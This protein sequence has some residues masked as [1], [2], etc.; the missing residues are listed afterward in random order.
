MTCQASWRRGASLLAALAG[1]VAGSLGV[2]GLGFPSPAAAAPT[3]T[4]DALSPSGASVPAPR[5]GG[6]MA[7]DGATGQVVLFG[8]LSGNGILLNDTWLWNG[9]SWTRAQP[10][11]SPAPT[12]GAAMAYDDNLRELILFGGET[13]PSRSDAPAVVSNQTWAWNGQSWYLIAT[14]VAPPARMGA[15]MGT[16]DGGSGQF[17]L[18]GGTAIDTA[19]AGRL[20]DDTWTF[21]G[22]AWTLRGP[23]ST[24]PPRSAA[25]SS[26]D[27]EAG[28]LVLFGGA[29]SQGPSPGQP[30]GVTTWLADTWTWDGQTWAQVATPV[31]PPARSGA[32]LSYDGDLHAG[33]LFGGQGAGG[34]ASD[35]WTFNGS[36]WVVL[37]P[38]HPPGPRFLATASW[39]SQTH[40][41]VLFGGAAGGGAVYGDTS[42]L[43]VVAASPPSSTTSTPPATTPPAPSPSATSTVPVQPGSTTPTTSHSRLPG[44][45][46]T[47]VP[48]TSPRAGGPGT[49]APAP[50][51]ATARTAST[52]QTVTLTGSGFAPGAAVTISFHSATVVLG[53]IRANS[54]GDFSLAV[55]IPAGAPE[56][57]HHL[58]A[59]GMDRA[60]SVVTMS[61]PIRVVPSPPSKSGPSA[62]TVVMVALAVLIPGGTWLVLHL[63]GAGGRRRRAN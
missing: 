52:G 37:T 44:Q 54:H 40:Q 57:P 15:T 28:G 22:S 7:Y 24:P 6:A 19:G 33:V 39:D 51:T 26:W 17:V 3:A 23:G 20:L 58:E 13:Q 18:F 9:T 63:L 31:S 1:T 25:V 14:P 49:G 36:A 56:G 59:S 32:T 38:G 42:A 48:T 60:G 11:T 45:P 4:W 53:S 16:Y 55:T 43:T 50:L 41:L 2:L 8:G 62:E 5:Q 46:T 35:T 61:T 21:D 10:T 29:V 34:P 47:T 27:P 30:E 12:Q